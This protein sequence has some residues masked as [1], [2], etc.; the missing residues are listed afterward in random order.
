MAREVEM[1]R[2]ERPASLWDWF[3]APDFGR[4]FEGLR[5]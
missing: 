3:E 5:P 2:E 1:K 4:W